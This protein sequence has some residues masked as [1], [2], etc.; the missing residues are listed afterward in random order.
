MADKADFAKLLLKHGYQGIK[1]I[2][3]GSFGVAV[4]VQDREGNKSVCK[5]VKVG[6][7]S[8]DDLVVAKKEARL[9]ANLQHPHIVRYRTSFLDWGWFCIVMDFCDGGS[10]QAHLEYAASKKQP[11][12]EA[13]VIRWF[14]QAVLALEYLHTKG[15]LHRD[16]KPGN[17]FLTLKGD[18]VVG[19]FGLSKVLDCTVACAKTMVGTPYYL[20]PEV[21][22]D[23]P[24]FWPSDMWAIGCILYE[25]CALKVPFDSE[26]LSKLAQRIC[27]DPIPEVPETY[28]VGLQKLCADLMNR[29]ANE[30]PSAED[31]LQ[32]PLLHAVAQA[33]RAG[34]KNAPEEDPKAKHVV[35]DQFRKFDLNSDGVI[36]RSEL[37]KVLRHLDSQLWTDEHISELLEAV[38]TTKD[39]LIQLDEFVQWVFGSGDAAES[40]G[41]VERCQQYK[42]TALESISKEDVAGFRSALKQW[43]QAADVGCLSI[44]PPSVCVDTCEGIGNIALALG[45]LL[46]KHAETDKAFFSECLDALDQLSS[47]LY[48]IEQLLVDYSKQ[49]VR[50]VLGLATSAGSSQS[51]LRGLCFELA[52]G[53]RVGQS[54]AGLGDSGLTVSGVKWEALADGEQ[55]LEVKGYAALPPRRPASSHSDH[56]GGRS[57]SPGPRRGSAAPGPGGGLPK[58]AF[59]KARSRFTLA[60][61]AKAKPKA[62]PGGRGEALVRQG[63]GA[64]EETQTPPPEPVEVVLAACVTLCTSSGRELTFGSTSSTARGAPFSFKAPPGEEVEDVIFAEGTCT[65]I[66]TSHAAPLVVSW[67]FWDKRKVE[68]VQGAFLLSADAVCSTLLRWSWHKGPQNGKYALLQARRFGLAKLYVPEA[69]LEKQEGNAT[70]MKPPTYW[71]LSRMQLSEG[72]TVG[73]IDLG[74]DGLEEMQALLSATYSQEPPSDSSRQRMPSGMEVVSGCRLQN[75]QS[76]AEYAAQQQRIGAELQAMRSKHKQLNLSLPGLKTGGCLPKLRLPLDEEAHCEWLFHS[77]SVEAAELTTTAAFDID[78]VGLS[79]STL[80]G[81]GIYLSECCS[82]ADKQSPPGTEEGLRCLLLCRVALGNMLYDDAVLPDVAQVTAKCIGGTCHSVVEVS[83][84]SSREFVVY[85]KDQVYPEFLLLY[86]RRYG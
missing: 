20:S 12:A 86:R 59:P 55:I 75:W 19:D 65:G 76:W 41:L 57:A 3:E 1:K 74:K 4:L 31:V 72:S 17:L 53:M 84:G 5:S 29:D 23:K 42:D 9:L 73:A 44:M 34:V 36:D 68:K 46:K 43:R 28:S 54:S 52:D 51:G 77:L 13:V 61:A 62:S 58:A 11:L 26:N 37:S 83:P 35:M 79:S 50:R 47:I 7:A 63:S 38:D 2:G 70:E 78:T 8:M 16:L 64:P 82:Q 10:L 39:G 67:D 40:L 80:Y 25:M 69:I 49:R 14:T 32:R 21:I 22:Q 24:Y 18:L 56:G 48:S 15:I 66:R 45:N 27:F 6:T 60:S 30:R 33:L 81:R 71:D 85:D